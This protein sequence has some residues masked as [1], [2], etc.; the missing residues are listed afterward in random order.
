MYLIMVMVLESNRSLF[1]PAAVAGGLSMSIYW[2]SLNTEY[3]RTSD[4]RKEGR[5][6]GLLIGLPNIA[7]VIGPVMGAAILAVAGFSMLMGLSVLL[8]FLSVV[9]LFMSHDY[10]SE[11]L[12]LR[13][14]E[15]LLDRRKALIYFG[16]GAIYAVDG[17][18]WGMYVFLSYGFVSLGI[19]AS[20]MGLGML[21]FVLVVGRLS[22]SASAR[23]RLI[24]ISGIMCAALWVM[25]FLAESELQVM[26]LSLLGGFILTSF[27][28]A[29]YADFARFAKE[30]G[31]V[32]GVVFRQFW[33]GAG[34]VLPSLAMLI[35]LSGLP[36]IEFL[37]ASFI[38]AALA[39]LALVT[40]KN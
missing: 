31:T 9:P 14:A 39:S 24:R 16:Q 13:G 5:E 19:A 25:R 26:V 28:V 4:R 6:A 20:L 11:G 36:D 27:G 34:Y 10:R 21:L 8:V 38:A 33:L 22:D 12:K 23:T 40:M 29:L 7:A 15:F 37:R 3:V 32:R 2:T 17:V 30:A 35:L 18:F 1:L